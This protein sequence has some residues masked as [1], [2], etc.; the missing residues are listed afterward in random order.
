VTRSKGWRRRPTVRVTVKTTKSKGW[1]RKTPVKRRP[2]P[3]VRRRR[4][5]RRTRRRVVRRKPV[6]PKRKCAPAHLRVWRAAMQADRRID[7]GFGSC[8]KSDADMLLAEG[9]DRIGFSVGFRHKN[10]RA[11]VRVGGG[12]GWRRRASRKPRRKAPA[13]RKTTRRV[14]RTRRRRVI[15][16]RRSVPGR[17]P[18]IRRARRLTRRAGCVSRSKSRVRNLFRKDAKFQRCLGQVNRM[19][20]GVSL[21]ETASGDEEM[22]MVED[23]DD[24]DS[25]DNDNDNEDEDDDDESLA[26]ADDEIADDDDDL[27]GDVLASRV[28]VRGRV[29]V[30]LRSKGWRRRSKRRGS[31]RASVRA[32][33]KGWRRRSKK[34]KR[35][36]RR[37]RTRRVVR[38]RSSGGRSGKCHT[39]S[40]ARKG[41]RLASAVRR[42]IDAAAA[43]RS[44]AE[45]RRLQ[46]LRA[47]R[48]SEKIDNAISKLKTKA[49]AA[50]YEAREIR[51]ENREAANKEATAEV[52]REKADHR[53][54]RER[55]FHNALD[56]QERTVRRWTYD[57]AR[58]V[59]QGFMNQ[60]HDRYMPRLDRLNRKISWHEVRAKMG[61]NLG[62]KDASLPSAST[63][64]LQTGAARK[65]M[66][67]EKLEARERTSTKS[68]ITAPAGPLG[69][70]T[71][72]APAGIDSTGTETDTAPAYS[73]L[74]DDSWTDP[75]GPETWG[76]TDL[77]SAKMRMKHLPKKDE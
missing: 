61:N 45:R 71:V 53:L 69:D 39:A 16:K 2:P 65:E 64:L 23:G 70:A 59:L 28:R 9:D 44:A 48:D 63:S 37:V 10:L 76:N 34:P 22:E 8:W 27:D 57:E 54:S 40:L 68:T 41:A 25:D 62:A 5:V 12:K 51:H 33:G 20:L 58:H 4:V 73:G 72:P 75:Y 43:R 32:G 24:N 26:L 60:F 11:G 56:A 67:L 29:S 3:V 36:V 17:R 38:R 77:G 31:A 14:R 7:P 66:A 30:G 42:C 50:R 49:R 55:S 6:K 18:S 15:R 52:I 1:R 13:R 46:R 19:G 74:R 21:L 47:R 35:R